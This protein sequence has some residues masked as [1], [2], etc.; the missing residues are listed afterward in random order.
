[1]RKPV[2]FAVAAV[3]FLVSQTAVLAQSGAVVFSEPGFPA[4]DS[5]MPSPQQLAAMLPGA[6]TASADHL[7][8][9]LAAPSAR[10]FVL[11]YGSVFP[12]EAWPAIKQFLE[13]GGYRTSCSRAARLGKFS[14]P[15][16]RTLTST[17]GR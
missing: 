1:M 17:A 11:P 7:Q 4:V 3:F 14:V 10:L 8:D 9:A 13:R 6:Q 2:L 16:K 12:E 5:A 15:S